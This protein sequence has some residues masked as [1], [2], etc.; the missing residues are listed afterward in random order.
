MKMGFV[1][2][3]GGASSGAI[4]FVVAVIFS[5]CAHDAWLTDAAINAKS[6]TPEE[7]V[8]QLGPP[9]KIVYNQE[10]RLHKGPTQEY[11]YFVIDR[12]G[13]VEVRQYFYDGQHWLTEMFPVIPVEGNSFKVISLANA[14]YKKQLDRL[15][16]A[17]P[18]LRP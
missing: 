18:D 11:R 14:R 4:L 10:L 6:K 12:S 5:G 15:W 2:Y 1:L 9:A 3:P 17:Y 16:N 13:R 7:L 8:R